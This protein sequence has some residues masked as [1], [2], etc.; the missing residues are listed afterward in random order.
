MRLD[1]LSSASGAA[2]WRALTGEQF[3]HTLDA[4]GVTT[5]LSA[6]LRA[7]V[8]GRGLKKGH[9][10]LRFR[11]MGD[12]VDALRQRPTTAK[13]WGPGV[14]RQLEELGRSLSAKVK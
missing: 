4:R 11:N 8:D 9:E 13:L 3:L 7:L 5:E 1:S 2:G 12:A 14:S 10:P 6:K